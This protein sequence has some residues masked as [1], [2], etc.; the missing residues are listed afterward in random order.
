MMNTQKIIP[1]N[2]ER[3]KSLVSFND[4][5]N[6][7]KQKPF[8]FWFTGLSG[9]GKTSI[10]VE[11]EKQLFEQGVIVFH[12]DADDLRKKL[13]ADLGFSDEERTENIRRAAAVARILQ[14]AGLVVLS[15]FITPTEANR[16]EARNAAREG[17]FCEVFIKASLE[18]CV[19]RDPKGFYAKALKDE[20]K[21][22]TGIQSQY[23]EP[24]CPDIILD[25]DRV[26]LNTC[27][28]H[29]ME[30]AKSHQIFKN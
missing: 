27:V 13:N 6:T 9:A 10:A 2:L 5:M 25:T 15:T 12:L 26:D 1:R 7:F 20:I 4:R 29:L 28:E 11:F 8:I 19:T 24:E 23:E 30:F 3:Q 21:D 22:Y 14:D 16:L 17:L 18:T